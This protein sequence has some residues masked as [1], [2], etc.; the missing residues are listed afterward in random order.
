MTIR[1]HVPDGPARGTGRPRWRPGG[2]EAPSMGEPERDD[3]SPREREESQRKQC[4]AERL[5]WRARIGLEVIK[6]GVV[7]VLLWAHDAGLPG[8]Q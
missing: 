5:Y 4:D 3:D 2:E 1:Q 7:I 8:L 6:T